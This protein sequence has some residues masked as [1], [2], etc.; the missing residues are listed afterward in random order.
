[1]TSLAIKG[2]SRTRFLGSPSLL[3]PLGVV[4]LVGPNIGAVDG[5]V[6]GAKLLYKKRQIIHWQGDEIT[7]LINAMEVSGLSSLNFWQLLY[8]IGD[9]RN[10][11]SGVN[12]SDQDHVWKGDG[13]KRL[14]RR[15]RRRRRR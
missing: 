13:D 5:A 15:H 8:L 4:L 6:D 1:M 12:V 11:P 14:H 7:G 3:L 2:R 9:R 10:S